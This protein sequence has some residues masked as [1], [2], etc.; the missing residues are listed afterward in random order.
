M[1]LTDKQ[2]RFV[3]E[4]LIDLNATQAAIRAGYNEKTARA[5]GCENLTK[6]DIAAAVAEAQ[7]K[8]SARTE[9]TQDRVLKELARIGFSDVRNLFS[10]SEERSTFVPSANLTEDQAAAVSAIESE[11]RTFVD[12]EGNAETTVKLKLRVYDKVAALEKIGKHLGMFVEKVEHS[13]EV[14]GGVLVVPTAVSAAEWSRV[15]ALQQSKNGAHAGNG[16]N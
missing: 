4:Y 13:G 11:T 9:I 15:A 10:W 12:R 1:S 2:A 7:A 3:E 5:I 6:P 8:R 14:S 16:S